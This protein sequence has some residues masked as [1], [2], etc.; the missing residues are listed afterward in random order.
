MIDRVRASRV[1]ERHPTLAYV[2]M[3]APEAKDQIVSG[4]WPN[5]HWMSAS[6]VVM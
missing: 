6:G 1:V 4:I 5:D 2:A 3:A